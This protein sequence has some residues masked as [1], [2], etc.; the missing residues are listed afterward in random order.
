MSG[1]NTAPPW[2]LQSTKQTLRP[3]ITLLK[4]FSN[5]RDSSCALA[6]TNG[7]SHSFVLDLFVS[8]SIKGK[9]KEITMHKKNHFSFMFLWLEPKEPKIQAKNIP[10]AIGTAVFGRP[11][12]MCSHQDCKY[13]L[14]SD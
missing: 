14:F 3:N 10:I 13:I 2:F 9:R 11:T 4:V 8:F 5:H 12:H 7:R 6:R 1:R